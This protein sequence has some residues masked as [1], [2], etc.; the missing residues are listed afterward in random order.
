MWKGRKSCW[1]SRKV[2][3]FACL[4]PRRIHFTKLLNVF[5]LA[6]ACLPACVR[7]PGCANVWEEK[8]WIFLCGGKFLRGWYAD[9]PGVPPRRML[10]HTDLPGA[11]VGD[12]EE[13]HAPQKIRRLDTANGWIDSGK[14]PEWTDG[15]YEETRNLFWRW[16]RKSEQEGKWFESGRTDRIKNIKQAGITLEQ[17]ISAASMSGRI[18]GFVSDVLRWS[19]IG[20]TT[21]LF[22]SIRII[23]SIEFSIFQLLL[24]TFFLEKNLF[25]FSGFYASIFSPQIRF[26]PSYKR[27]TF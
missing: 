27:L 10:G 20:T 3:F 5:S 12:D 24:T 21:S 7:R 11:A 18:C 17:G 23:Q 6:C 15:K 8:K 9:E 22:K 2:K 13:L 25:H 19:V 14:N 26:V 16:V 1:K 4:C